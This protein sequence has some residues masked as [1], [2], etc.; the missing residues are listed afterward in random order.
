MTAKVP[1]ASGLLDQIAMTKHASASIGGARLKMLATENK[2]DVIEEGQSQEECDTEGG[3]SR[4]GNAILNNFGAIL[5][6]KRNGEGGPG[7][8]TPS[9]EEGSFS[10]ADLTDQEATKTRQ[11][12]GR[13]APSDFESAMFMTHVNEDG[14]EHPTKTT[15]E[16]PNT[17]RSGGSG[18]LAKLGLYG[19][20]SAI[21]RRVRSKKNIQKDMKRNFNKKMQSAF[22]QLQKHRKTRS[23]AGLDGH[24]S[25]LFSIF[26]VPHI[27]NSY[28]RLKQVKMTEFH[29]DM[30]RQG[31]SDISFDFDK[32]VFVQTIEYY[33][34]QA[35]EAFEKRD[36]DTFTQSM[37]Y[38]AYMSLIKREFQMSMK[39]YNLMGH[40]FKVWRMWYDACNFYKRLRDTAR[41]AADIETCMYAFK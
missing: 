2:A 24:G 26:N 17:Q 22:E 19:I 3:M 36:P 29:E 8:L 27:K 10:R 31:F 38:I 15:T 32:M 1:R 4:A 16:N 39:I 21:T 6:A 40:T 34:L 23:P 28:E 9:N 37:T 14:E 11:A 33:L 41:M 13:D 35:I 20:A 30:D 25:G 12:L 5:V 7:I 18:P